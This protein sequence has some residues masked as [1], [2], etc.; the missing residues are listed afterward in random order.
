VPVVGSQISAELLT[1][2]SSLLTWL[3]PVA[4]TLPF[5]RTAAFTSRRCVDIE[6]V[7]V[8]T[9]VP[10]VMS[11]TTAPF[12]APPNCRMR[13]G[14]NIAALASLAVYWLGNWAPKVIVPVL[15]GLT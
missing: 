2:V 15:A 3:P 7:G 13:P 12:E 9:G 14:R 8:T 6:E 1:P 10:E 4:S 5:G 11:I